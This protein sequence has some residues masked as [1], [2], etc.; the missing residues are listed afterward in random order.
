MR[1]S[2][3]HQGFTL[4]ELLVVVVIIAAIASITLPELNST[5]R[6]QLESATRDVAQAIRYAR[7]ES[8]R[9]Q[10]PHGIEYSASSNTI[11]VYRFTDVTDPTPVYDVY[12]P[13]DKLIYSLDFSA[14]GAY[15]PLTLQTVSL[16]FAGNVTNRTRMHFDEYG[17]P[18]YYNAG[19]YEML[20]TG[21]VFLTDG[22]NKASITLTPMV[23]RV[24]ISL[25]DG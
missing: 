5:S 13:I 4:L 21:Q 6:F 7:E 25:V 15:S 1:P 14:N 9:T 12:H 20:D 10:V 24:S 16:L 8:I 2:T 18:R 17:V 22:E 19:D 3:K 11:A 23:G